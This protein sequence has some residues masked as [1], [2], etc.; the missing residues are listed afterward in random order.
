M[1]KT[2]SRELCRN[3]L[4]LYSKC[5]ETL[6]YIVQSFMYILNSFTEVDILCFGCME[7]KK[8]SFVFH[9]KVKT[10]SCYFE[11]NLD[12]PLSFTLKKVFAPLHSA[13]APLYSKFFKPPNWLKHQ[14]H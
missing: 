14:K 7:V 13:L 12:T 1:P 6:M 10:P 5:T 8:I 11:K 3:L 4:I 9:K 2:F